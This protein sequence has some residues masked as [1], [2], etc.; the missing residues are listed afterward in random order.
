MLLLA[1]VGSNISQSTKEPLN[2]RRVSPKTGIDQTKAGDKFRV[3]LSSKFDLVWTDWSCSLYDKSLAGL[4]ISHSVSTRLPTFDIK[5]SHPLYF[6]THAFARLL[7][8]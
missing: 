2:R 3:L 5:T 8:I 7:H 4:L 1:R 6:V